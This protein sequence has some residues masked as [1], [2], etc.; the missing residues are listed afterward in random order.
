MELTLRHSFYETGKY[1]E[2]SDI[3]RDKLYTEVHCKYWL[4]LK[5]VI[6]VNK[7]V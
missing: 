3:K 6:P 4:V 2:V 1:R 7:V 5:I